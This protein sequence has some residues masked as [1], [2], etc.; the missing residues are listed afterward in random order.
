MRVR[1]YDKCTNG[2]F[3]S[4]VYAIINTGYYKKYLVVESIDNK[5]YFRLVEYLDKSKSNLPVNINVISS[6]D[7]SESWVYKEDSDLKDISDSLDV[8][9]KND[10]FYRYRGYDF[11]LEQKNLLIVLLKGEQ[12]AYE[13]LRGNEKEISTKLEGW[14]YVESEE[15][16]P[17]LMKTFNIF[18]DSLLRNLN[19]VS[20]SGKGE[21]GIN[22]TD[23]IRQISMIFDSLWSNSIEIVFEG[24]LVLNLRPAQDNY[25]SDLFSA[26][27]I[28]KDKTILFYDDEVNSEQ[29][30]YEGTW[31]NALGMRWRFADSL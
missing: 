30:N 4:E 20:G 14:N 22:V 23:N 17:T 1:V 27:I 15:D 2:Y 24:L 19:Y 7:L 21:K 8:K 11:I 16:I 5:R 25:C 12:V 29:E 3:I 6:I 26:T 31:V 28:L 18:H 13:L 10:S 9:D